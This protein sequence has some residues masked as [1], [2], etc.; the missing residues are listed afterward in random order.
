MLSHWRKRRGPFDIAMIMG[1]GGSSSDAFSRRVRLIA[2]RMA[3][4]VYVC[5]CVYLHCRRSSLLKSEPPVFPPRT[6]K[7]AR[8]HAFLRLSTH[9]YN[10]NVVRERRQRQP[11]PVATRCSGTGGNKATDHPFMYT[12]SLHPVRSKPARFMYTTSVR[13]SVWRACI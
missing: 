11:A 9:S 7:R 8:A 4:T 6:N 12:H 2:V 1:E 3:D 13:V 10:K 5:V